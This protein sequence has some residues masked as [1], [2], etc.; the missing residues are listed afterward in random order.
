LDYDFKKH[1]LFE[2]VLRNLKDFARDFNGY[3]DF[4]RLFR[5]NKKN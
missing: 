3:R 4:K 1:L 2:K 5:F